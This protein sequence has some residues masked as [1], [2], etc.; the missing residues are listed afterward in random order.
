METS[1]IR[2]D[3][4]V[5]HFTREDQP[6]PAPGSLFHESDFGYQERSSFDAWRAS[7]QME[8]DSSSSSSSFFPQ[9]KVDP[10]KRSSIFS[11]RVYRQSVAKLPRTSLVINISSSVMNPTCDAGQVLS[12][13]LTTRSKEELKNLWTMNL[14]ASCG[15]NNSTTSQISAAIHS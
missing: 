13:I 9:V 3:K 1:E 15:I 5:T 7:M 10:V 8:I 4:Q 14:I 6:L 12:Q 11:E 2:E